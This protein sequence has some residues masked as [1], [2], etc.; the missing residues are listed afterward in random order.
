[1][2]PRI[3]LLE[4]PK[5][6]LDL[7]TVGELLSVI[8]ELVSQEEMTAII[9]AHEMGFARDVSDRIIVSADGAIIDS[10]A[11]KGVFTSP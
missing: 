5:A 8:R 2:K 4:E 9:S 10:G 6:S 11:P 7:E 1:M 3:M